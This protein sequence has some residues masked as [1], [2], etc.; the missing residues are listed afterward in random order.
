MGG[1]GPSMMGKGRDDMGGG[2]GNRRYFP[3]MEVPCPLCPAPSMEVP[4]SPLHCTSPCP[5]SLCL[6]PSWSSVVPVLL[7]LWRAPCPPAPLLRRGSPVPLPVPHSQASEGRVLRSAGFT[8]PA[9]WLRVHSLYLEHTSPS[10]SERFSAGVP[11]RF[12]K[13]A[14]SDSLVG[15]LT[16]SP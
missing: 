14:M 6:A 10:S 7:P 3:I 5:L 11:C 15:A 4:L 2:M 13:L 9:S 12:L 8:S 16:P 1:R